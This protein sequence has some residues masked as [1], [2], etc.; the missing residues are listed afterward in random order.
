MDYKTIWQFAYEA[1]KGDGGFSNGGYI[2]KY[3]R[4]SDEKYSN[5]QQIAFYTNLFAPN[6][7]RY[8]GYIFKNRPIRTTSNKFIQMIFDDC[9]KKGNNVNIFM[10][11]FA[12][13]SKVRGIGIVLVDMPKDVGQTIGD[14]L[15]KRALP[16]FTSIAP[17]DITEY[18]IDAYGNF[19]YIKFKDTIDKSEPG[20]PNII[21]VERYFDKTSWIVYQ[22]GEI[23]ESGEHNLGVTPAMIFSE[24]GK[25]PDI[26]EFT[27]VASIAKRLYNLRSELDEIMRGQTFSVLTIQA[28]TPS[29]F[30]IKLSTDNAIIYGKEMTRPSFIAPEVGP[31]NIY[32]EEIEKL[33][34]LIDKITYNFTTNQ[35][36]ES[37][38]ALDI[39]FQGLNSSLSNFAMR[40]E[41]FEARLFD[42]V[43]KYLNITNDVTIQYSKNFSIVDITKEFSTLEAFK[44]LGYSAPTYERLKL[45]QI[46]NNDL[47]SIDIEDM[48]KIK[49]ELEYLDKK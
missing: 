2:D 30:E 39:K 14:Q 20:N 37:G 36:Q 29:D 25:F 48:D 4:E 6:V 22:G 31:A 45:L 23:I 44:E 16:F 21:N 11:N 33:E 32:Q 13:E 5:R 41:D 26:G 49:I 34:A 8:I 40:L 7:S 42:I 10:S 12:K 27:Q 3:P 35:A 17:E 46:I 47:N 9:D 18:K 19:E 15:K 24:T 1:Y 43:C 28:D 38:I